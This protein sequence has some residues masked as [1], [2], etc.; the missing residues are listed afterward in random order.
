MSENDLRWVMEYLESAEFKAKLRRTL[1]GALTGTLHDHGTNETY[2]GSVIKRMSGQVYGLLKTDL[3]QQVRRMAT[4]ASREA[5]G[6]SGATGRTT[7]EKI[8][9]QARVADASTTTGVASQPVAILSAENGQLRTQVSGR[10]EDPEPVE[11]PG[12]NPV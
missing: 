6:D 2:R 11:I 8:R 3:P 12:P 4:A 7:P 9:I 10:L 1:S 5:A